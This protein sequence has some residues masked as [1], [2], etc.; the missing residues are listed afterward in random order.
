MMTFGYCCLVFALVVYV[1]NFKEVNKDFVEIWKSL[2]KEAR[3]QYFL[4]HLSIHHNIYQFLYFHQFLLSFPHINLLRMVPKK[5][6][7]RI[8]TRLRQKPALRTSNCTEVS[9]VQFLESML[10]TKLFSLPST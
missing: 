8:L 4:E 10:N 7:P 3:E 9:K 2:L 6:S 1:T 5:S